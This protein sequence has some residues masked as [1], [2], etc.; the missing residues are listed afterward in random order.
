M[1]KSKES[2]ER[3]LE[4]NRTKADE[5]SKTIERNF[6]KDSHTYESATMPGLGSKEK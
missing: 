1:Q 4:L 3:K 6:K 5:I 2:L